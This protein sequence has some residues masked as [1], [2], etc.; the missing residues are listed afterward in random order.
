MTT[1]LQVIAPITEEQW[2]RMGHAA[3]RRMLHNI[4]ML[5]RALNADARTVDLVEEQREA[6]KVRAE[7]IEARRELIAACSELD[8]VRATTAKA[9]AE[10]DHTLRSI[11][12]AEDL[13][14]EDT[15]SAARR[16]LKDA[17][18]EAEQFSRRRS[19]VV[20]GHIA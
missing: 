6:A 3:R 2:N 8:R 11:V 16:R 10:H 12:H 20:I 9:K 14:V 17:T 7:A 1:G 13:L 4:N 5:V 19:R 15:L 18:R